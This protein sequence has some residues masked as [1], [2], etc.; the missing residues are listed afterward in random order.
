[1]A[2]PFP[3]TADLPD[4]FE[5]LYTEWV[6]LK[7]LL[8]PVAD[9]VLNGGR[10]DART[11]KR[12]GLIPVHKRLVTLQA[13]HPEV[14]EMYTEPFRRLELLLEFLLKFGQATPPKDS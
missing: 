12:T 14:T 4:E 2:R 6:A 7:D 1:L 10:L 13:E 9:T 8:M 3:L 5:D 11:L